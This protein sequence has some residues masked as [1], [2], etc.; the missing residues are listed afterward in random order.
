MESAAIDGSSVVVMDY[1]KRINRA[2]VFMQDN[3]FRQLNVKEI[4]ETANFSPFHF[5]RIFTAFTGE[6][7]FEYLTRIRMNKAVEMLLAGYRTSQIA[8]ETGYQTTAAFNKV[9]KR[10]YGCPPNVYKQ[11]PLG[12]SIIGVTVTQTFTKLDLN[13]VIAILPGMCLLYVRRKGRVYGQRTK[14]AD[15]AFYC[16]YAYLERYVGNPRLLK[17]LGIMHDLHEI[18]AG[19]C[20]YDAC[21]V[22][23]DVNK[24][25]LTNE[26]QTATV[27]AGKWVVFLHK[28]PYDTLWQT[29]NRIYRCW[30]P[31]S[32]L[33]LRDEVPFEVYHNS[34]LYTQPGELLTDIHIPVL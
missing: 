27:G 10:K 13:P 5:H 22:V 19:E 7:I 12:N 31:S 18:N 28:G 9:F 3:A 15:E 1:R 33:E 29:W 11:K 24:F 34:P 21:V 2:S 26:I 17:R 6:P 4:A 14:A 30:L 23:D 32:G 8:T 16:L 25:V 20:R